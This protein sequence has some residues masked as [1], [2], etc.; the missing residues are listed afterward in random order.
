MFFLTVGDSLNIL[1]DV[2]N[3]KLTFHSVVLQTF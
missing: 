2:S 1:V 3:L